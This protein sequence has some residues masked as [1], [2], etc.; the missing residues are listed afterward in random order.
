MEEVMGSIK[1]D[2]LDLAVTDILGAQLQEISDTSIL[3]H[4]I[5][6]M[7]GISFMMDTTS[8]EPEYTLKEKKRLMVTYMKDVR[9]QVVEEMA[10]EPEFLEEYNKVSADLIMEVINIEL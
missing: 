10:D 4:L 7:C 5:Y 1:P 3:M 9:R 8:D 2:V 6:V